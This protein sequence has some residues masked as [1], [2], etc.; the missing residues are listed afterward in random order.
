MTSITVTVE[1]DDGSE[2]GWFV[3]LLSWAPNDVHLIVHDLKF[4]GEHDKKFHFS[5]ADLPSG[6]YGLR[7]A[8]QGPGRKVG[9]SVTSPSAIFYPAG[10]SW[11]LSLKV[12]TTTT[13][14]S[15]TWFFRT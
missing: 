7:L 8:L 9:A 5:S 6:E 2:V 15:N 12:P 1:D 14:T 4:V 3:Q 13:Q 11:P 10:K